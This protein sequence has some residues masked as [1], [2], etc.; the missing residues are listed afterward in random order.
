MT[1]AAEAFAEWADAMRN[2]IEMQNRIGENKM[3]TFA[4]RMGMEY[5]QEFNVNG[6]RFF[7]SPHTGALTSERTTTQEDQEMAMALVLGE[8]EIDHGYTQEQKALVQGLCLG[9]DLYLI[10]RVKSRSIEGIVLRNR[11]GADI[12]VSNWIQKNKVLFGLLDGILV[13][14]ESVDVEEVLR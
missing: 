6:R 8:V 3:K 1:D 9:R 10:E 12:E 5:G 14:R 7:V 2:L 4:E 11:S 13:G